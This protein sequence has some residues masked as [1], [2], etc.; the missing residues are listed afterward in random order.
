MVCPTSVVADGWVAVVEP[1]NVVRLVPTF[2]GSGACGHHHAPRP[3]GVAG[4]G[5]VL[6]VQPD[7][8]VRLP[9]TRGGRREAARTN[10]S[11]F[12]S[13]VIDIEQLR[14]RRAHR[15]PTGKDVRAELAQLTD[16]G[17]IHPQEPLPRADPGPARGVPPR[18]HRE[19]DRAAAGA[20]RVGG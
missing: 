16:E 17:R 18:R 12:V 5:C 7:I 3:P 19:A 14:H 15:S 9:A 2:W 11:T 4:Q 1:Y 6:A 8:T 20:G 10:G 13:G